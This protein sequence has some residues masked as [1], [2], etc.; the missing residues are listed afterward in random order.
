[1]CST[2]MTLYLCTLPGN[3]RKTKRLTGHGHGS[4]NDSNI[5]SLDF[6]R[7]PIPGI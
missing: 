6:P 1:M 3:K 4:A 2:F 7:I 5:R